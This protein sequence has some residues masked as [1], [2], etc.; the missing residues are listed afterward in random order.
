MLVLEI[1]LSFHFTQIFM[2]KNVPIETKKLKENLKKQDEDIV[3]ELDINL[4]FILAI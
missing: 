4:L 1:S 3:H 2:P